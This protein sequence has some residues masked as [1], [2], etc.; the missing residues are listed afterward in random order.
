VNDR[1]RRKSG[2]KRTYSKNEEV[3]EDDDDDGK[4]KLTKALQPNKKE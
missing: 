2:S 4:E 1:W 3:K